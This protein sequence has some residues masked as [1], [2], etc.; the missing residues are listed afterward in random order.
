MGVAVSSPFA[1][2]SDVKN[3]LQSVT[4]KSI[5]FD[6]DEAKTLVRSIS[7]N[8]L[9]PEP[10]ISISVGSKKMVSEG[11]VSF[12]GLDLEQSVSAKSPPLDKPGN[13]PIKAFIETPKQSPVFDPSNPQHEAAIR[14]QK[15]KLA[16]CAVLV[17]QIWWK[18]LDFAELKR[19]S[20]SFFDIGKHETAISRWSRARTRA[21]KVGKGLSKNKKAQKLALQHWL[22]A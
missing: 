17:E 16:D 1:K 12:K 13:V 21:A 9:E 15:V 5:H 7:Y 19:S 10:L 20:I 14:L 3:G 22:E 6:E 11:S 2:P 8:S 18:L 4:V